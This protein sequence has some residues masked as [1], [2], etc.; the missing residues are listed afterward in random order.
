MKQTHIRQ[1]KKCCD[2][3]SQERYESTEMHIDFGYMGFCSHFAYISLMSG[4]LRDRIANGYAFN[5]NPYFF[6]FFPF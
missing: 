2:G 3:G 5:I 6:L 4:Y 1:C